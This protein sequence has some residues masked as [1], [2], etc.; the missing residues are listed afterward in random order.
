MPA[1]LHLVFTKGTSTKTIIISEPNPNLK[2][3]QAYEAMQAI[4]DK[5]AVLAAGEPVDGIKKA[6]L[7]EVIVTELEDSAA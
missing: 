7:S 3:A 5:K 6:Y 2:K 4:V 1:S